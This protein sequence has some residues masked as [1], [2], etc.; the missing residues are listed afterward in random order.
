[1]LDGRADLLQELQR[2]MRPDRD[3]QRAGPA[4][5]VLEH[6]HRAQL[7]PRNLGNDQPAMVAPVIA[8]FPDR[9]KINICLDLLFHV[10]NMSVT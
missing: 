1:V 8:G 3:P 5:P 6:L 9:F 4:D 10:A 2:Q 7:Q